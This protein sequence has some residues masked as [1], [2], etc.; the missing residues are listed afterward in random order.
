MR[1]PQTATLS[2]YGGAKQN[3][4]PVENPTTDISAEEHNELAEDVAAMTHT[5]LRA[6]C[7]F[8]GNATTPTD[9]SS[10]V[11]DAVFGDSLAMKPIAARPGTGV[12]T[13][14]YPTTYTDELGNTRTV[15]FR[16]G[17]VLSVEGTTPY[18][19]TVTPTAANVLTVRIFDH[20]GVANDAVGVTI[21]V[22]AV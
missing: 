19:V 8:V 20:A 18:L 3:E 15:N 11:H 21:V 1:L 12:W 5:A 2:T 17:I 10:N 13:L 16:R 7:A 9:P 14:T 6:W 22:G 4:Y